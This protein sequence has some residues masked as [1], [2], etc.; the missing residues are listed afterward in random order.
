[1]RLEIE[2][3]KSALKDLKSLPRD[4]QERVIGVLLR[5]RSN[6]YRYSKKLA[7]TDFYKVRVGDYRIINWIS[8]KIYVLKIAHRKKIY[9]YF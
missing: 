9:R 8:D 5:I 6:P 3:T 4:I 2:F 7:G 1:M